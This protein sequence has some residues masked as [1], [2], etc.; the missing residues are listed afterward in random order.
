M[1]L[2]IRT[3][4]DAEFYEKY[5]GT[6]DGATISN[7]R[8]V[9]EEGD[10]ADHEFW[11]TFDV[12]TKD[13][14]KFKDCAIS[15]DEE[16]NGPG[17]IFGLPTPGQDDDEQEQPTSDDGEGPVRELRYRSK[18]GEVLVD[19]KV[20][21]TVKR[22]ANRRYEARRAHGELISSEYVGK[23][24]AMTFLARWANDLAVGDRYKIA[25]VPNANGGPWTV[26]DPARTR[27]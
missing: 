19:G 13:G 18:T 4:K 7:V 21:G 25:G 23:V 17:F 5:F 10:Y 15:Q 27:S 24:D 20:I 8:M 16:G 2:H 6:L 11:P 9:Q 14:Q 1:G 22:L 3:K 26:L 12:T